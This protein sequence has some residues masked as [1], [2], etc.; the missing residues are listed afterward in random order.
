M[1][2]LLTLILCSNRRKIPLVPV[3]SV[4]TGICYTIGVSSARST[5]EA[6]VRPSQS[7]HPFLLKCRIYLNVP[8][9]LH[10]VEISLFFLLYL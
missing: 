8:L 2:V 7:R 3:L 5:L 9:P 10:N 6:S 4:E 1:F